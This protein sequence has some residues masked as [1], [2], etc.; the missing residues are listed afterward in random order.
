[1]GFGGPSAFCS[2]PAAGLSSWSRLRVTQGACPDPLRKFGPWPKSVARALGVQSGKSARGG[3]PITSSRPGPWKPTCIIHY[4]QVKEMS[5]VSC[6]IWD[7]EC[8]Q[9]RQTLH[10]DGKVFPSHQ[11]AR[12]AT[13]YIIRSTQLICVPLCEISQV[14]TNP[15]PT[16]QG[17][18][19]AKLIL[20]Y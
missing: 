17:P 3:I 7:L 18:S 12:H 1:M 10:G 6:D 4:Q 2:L 16:L 19:F 9:C 14:Q 11:H 20:I 13:I 5:D 15:Q 8:H